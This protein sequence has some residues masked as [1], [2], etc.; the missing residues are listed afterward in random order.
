MVFIGDDYVAMFQ[1]HD[2]IV[3][4]YLIKRTSSSLSTNADFPPV[5]S[6]IIRR[7]VGDY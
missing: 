3:G 2:L 5:S 1:D 4:F 6:M 7:S